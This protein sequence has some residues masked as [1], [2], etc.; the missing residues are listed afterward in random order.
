MRKK[1]C[2]LVLALSGALVGCGGEGDN[3]NDSSTLPDY[4]PNGSSGTLYYAQD[5]LRETN[6]VSTFY[7]D[8]AENMEASDGSEVT[9][10]SVSPLGNHKT[11]EPISVY[12]QGFTIDANDAKVCDYQYQVG[13]GVARQSGAISG[14]GYAQATVRVAVG[15]TT[16]QL[17][18]I[19]DNT[20][21]N[22]A[23]SVDIKAALSLVSYNLDTSVYSLSET[24]NLVNGDATHSLAIANPAENTIDYTPGAGIFTGV[25]RILYSY[26]DGTNVLTG[27]LDIAVSTETNNAPIAYSAE[28]TEIPDPETG[29]LLESAP[30]NQTV[31]L[32]IGSLISDPDGD[33]LQLIDVYTFDAFVTIPED[34][35]GDGNLFND[36]V[37][38]LTS[39][40][41]GNQDVTYVVTDNNGGFATG[42]VSIPVE[43]V[44]EP[45]TIVS[46]N[47]IV[48]PPLTGKQAEIGGIVFTP[49]TPGDGVTAIDSLVTATHTWDIANSVCEARGEELASESVLRALYNENPSSGIFANHNYPVDLNYWT[50]DVSGDQA[51]TFNFNNGTTKNSTIDSSYYLMCLAVSYSLE[52]EGETLVTA[53]STSTENQVVTYQ[54]KKIFADSSLPEVVASPEWSMSTELDYIILNEN[55]GSFEVDPLLMGFESQDGT[56]HITGC[57]EL[58]LC[59]ELDVIIQADWQPEYYTANGVDITP[60]FTLEKAQQLG[61]PASIDTANDSYAADSSF[62]EYIELHN[63]T[64]PRKLCANL[65]Y[66][67]GGWSEVYNRDDI[68]TYIQAFW[69][70]T[71]N[72]RTNNRPAWEQLKLRLNGGTGRYSYNDHLVVNEYTYQFGIDLNAE[73]GTTYAF[74]KSSRPVNEFGDP[75]HPFMACMRPSL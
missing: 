59:T 63:G 37:F 15:E 33:T 72:M 75:N 70:V 43:N 38:E 69:A 2:C 71:R 56:V 16:E 47:S 55:N 49:S 61:L 74:D 26:S 13:S 21:S 51:V 22:T 1:L 54:L 29:E 48:S 28:L 52:I 7:I 65:D 8:L 66:Q 17:P 27:M 20:A 4:Q 73:D 10:T 5:V 46:I 24:V 45:I 32:D 18:P 6:S 34:S 30:W 35:N 57:D 62:P 58:G 50:A 42:V 64:D 53:N 12:R 23:V 44:Y 68:D 31:T 9:L 11:C 14:D 19:S 3:T 67:G 39:S 36:T 41:P 25:E 60:F 40:Q